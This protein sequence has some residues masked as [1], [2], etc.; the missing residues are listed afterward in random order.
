MVATRMSVGLMIESAAALIDPDTVTSG[1]PVQCLVPP[2]A[3]T[4][5]LRSHIGRA[6]DR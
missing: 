6:Y 5:L 4:L 2:K 1:R 3:A